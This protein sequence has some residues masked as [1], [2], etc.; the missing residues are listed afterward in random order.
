MAGDTV[1]FG[2]DDGTTGREPWAL[3]FSL[4]EESI[5]RLIEATEGL[6]DDGRFVLQTPH[7]V[8]LLNWSMMGGLAGGILSEI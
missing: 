2:A 8:I 6:V 3:E 7:P 5:Q 4:P 1:L